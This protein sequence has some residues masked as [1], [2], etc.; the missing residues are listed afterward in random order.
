MFPHSSFQTAGANPG[1][2]TVSLDLPGLFKHP[3]NTP[4]FGGGILRRL[5]PP[6]S[7]VKQTSA[8]LPCG[9]LHKTKTRF[10]SRQLPWPRE[11]PLGA[12]AI[13]HSTSALQTVRPVCPPLVLL[14]EL[15]RYDPQGARLQ[16]LVLECRAAR[17]SNRFPDNLLFKHPLRISP[18]R[19]YCG[20]TDRKITPDHGP[21]SSSFWL[22]TA[23]KSL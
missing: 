4:V 14:Q 23:R 7:P 20:E 10:A 9:W 2:R 8:A 16:P 1:P 22:R 11:T 15:P 12:G 18:G 19:A 13:R 6:V 17:A 3:L 5:L 21:K